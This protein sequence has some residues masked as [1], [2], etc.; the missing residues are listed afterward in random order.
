MASLESQLQRNIADFINI[1]AH[2]KK[3]TNHYNALRDTIYSTLK[4]EMPLGKW[5]CGHKLGG[6]YGD[7]VK[8]TKPDEFD[9]VIYLKFPE[10]DRIIVKRDPRK[11]GNVTL[12]MTEVLNIL[13]RQDHQK[14]SFTALKKI[15][16]AQNLLLED[17]L[18]DLING[19]FTKVLNKMEK[20]IIVDGMTS[21]I[22]YRR[23]GPAHTIFINSPYK[24]SVDFVPAIRL[25]ERQNVLGGEELRFFRN[26]PYWDAIPK[27]MK[28]F[29]ANNISFRA[30]YYDAEKEMMHNKQKLK[31]VIK[32]MKKFRDSKTN[33]ANVRSYYIKTVLL[34]QVKVRPV[35]YWSNKRLYEILIDMY[36][37]LASCLAV[38]QRRGK[39]RFFWDPNLDMF[40][41]FTPTQRQDMFNCVIAEHANLKR[42]AGNLTSDIN[43]IVRSSYSSREERG[44]PQRR[45]RNGQPAVAPAPPSA[46]KPQAEQSTCIIG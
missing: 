1:D 26:I 11:P 8:I 34:W 5:L 18:Q 9:L 39:L 10:N 13:Q 36:D 20:R 17:K 42:A 6:S 32:L 3:Y 28:P 14:D 21:Q 7:K 25:S 27:P 35:S 45:P 46:N 41:A 2:R 24:Y 12:D 43:Q 40:A 33:M 38:N 29:Q 22:I 44:E 30:S 37:E 19:A 4:S 31:D 16:T 15:V 23:C